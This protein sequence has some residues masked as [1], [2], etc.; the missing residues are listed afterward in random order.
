MGE[1]FIGGVPERPLEPQVTP[2]P[3][4]EPEAASVPGHE[5]TDPITTEAREAATANR[6]EGAGFRLI[7]GAWRR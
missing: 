3:L 6:L 1:G 2:N 4:P 5:R 7:R